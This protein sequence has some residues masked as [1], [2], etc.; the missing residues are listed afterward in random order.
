[1]NKFIATNNDAGRTLLKFLE[2]ILDGVPKSR[3]EKAFREKEIKVNQK[4]IKDKKYIIQ[5][6]DDIEVYGIRYSVKTFVKVSHKFEII[7]EDK[8]ILIVNKPT[9]IEVHGPD[10]SLDMQVLSYLKF[11]KKDS[12]IPSHIGRID[13]VTS[14]I[15]VYGKNYETVRQMND[16]I[17]KFDKIY[18]A[19][20]SLK[21]TQVLNA[22]IHHNELDKKEYVSEEFGKECST[23]FTVMENGEIEAQIITGRKHQIRA[24][25]EF[26]NTPIKGDVKYGGAAASR[27]YLHSYMIIFHNLK[28]ELEYL[29][30]KE[31]KTGPYFEE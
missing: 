1:M 5:E 14:G 16:N 31:F 24:S 23:K 7:F 18:R 19:I 11:E 17:D 3:I 6:G 9:N 4:R 28:G 15:M 25:L 10:N 20:S 26:L 12:F 21:E 13:K 22:M 8:N 27:V 29:N 30:N 2:G